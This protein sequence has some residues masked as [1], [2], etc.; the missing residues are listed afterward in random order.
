MRFNFLQNIKLILVLIFM[1]SFLALGQ[2]NSDFNVPVQACINEL[3]SLEN[4]S[5]AN[6]QTYEWEFCPGDIEA[7]PTIA[8]ILEDGLF[9]RTFAIDYMQVDSTWVAFVPSRANDELLR[10]DYGNDPNNTPNIINLGNIGNLLDGPVSIDFMKEGNDWFAFIVNLDDGELLRLEFGDDILSTPTITALGGVLGTF[11]NPDA[12]EL[13]R[14]NAEFKAIVLA[15][16]IVH[17]V[18]F[19]SSYRNDPSMT[20]FTIP[21]TT[22]LWDISLIKSGNNWYGMATDFSGGDVYHLDFGTNVTSSATVTQ[23]NLMGNAIGSP[24]DIQLVREG[25]EFYAINIAR[26]GILYRFDFGTDI[27]STSPLI[28]TI[29]NLGQIAAEAAGLSL[30]RFGTGWQALVSNFR[31]NE[32]YRLDFSIPCL[33][34][35]GYSEEFEPQGLRYSSNGSQQITLTVFDENGN[36]DTNA[37]V[38]DIIASEAPDIALTS[39]NVCVSSPISFMSQ[40]SSNNLTSYSW[41]FGDGSISTDTNPDHSYMAP[42]DYNVTLSVV[43]SDGCSNSTNQTITIFPEPQPSFDFPAGPVC[44]NQST[45]VENTTPGDFEGNISYEWQLNG[46]PVAFTEDLEN[47][48]FVT[49]GDQE[50]KL[51]ASI[52]GCSV[53]IVENITNVSVGATPEFTVDDACVGTLMQF[54]NTSTGDI[55]STSWDF[56]NGFTSTL[57]NPAFEYSEPGTY[58]VTLSLLNNDGCLSEITESVTVYQSP[59]VQFTNELSCEG[60]PTHASSTVNSGVA[61]TDTLVMFSTI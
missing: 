11:S 35:L 32:I 42:G 41:D 8:N 19:G 49:P 22:R 34:E 9:D 55:S 37:Q 24:A 10:L 44:T 29:G 53:E 48:I 30:I 6:A 43:S 60:S 18:N 20:S 15:G 23:I 39:Q 50:L 16:S 17:V 28:N 4:L 27:S 40:N 31:E 51:I 5:S 56:G 59:Q 2:V 38:I 25:T 54:S 7:V 45:F 21:G 52:P 14:D 47:L 12:V 3:I 58:E 61:P 13:I 57:E 46:Q 33:T 1:P 26:S 36:N